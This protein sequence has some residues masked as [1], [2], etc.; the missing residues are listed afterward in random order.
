MTLLIAK[1]SY[2]HSFLKATAVRTKLLVL[3]CLGTSIFLAGLLMN[4]SYSVRREQSP[5]EAGAKIV[6]KSQG[7]FQRALNLAQPGDIIELEAGAVFTGPFT[8]PVKS[9]SEYITIQSS[10]LTE[11]PGDGK[12]VNSSH[13][14]LMP[15][16]VGV[17][18]EPAIKTA[19]KAHH[20]RFIGVEFAPANNRMVI[21]DLIKLGDG[22][23]AQNSLELVAH[24]FILDRCYIHGFPTQEVKRG[25]ALNS[26]ETWITNSYIS[27]IHGIGYD[28]QAICGWNG[29]G[30]YHIINNYLEGAGE[31]VMFG[32]AD[33]AI[34]NLVPSDIEIRRNHFFKPLSWKV[35]DP[36]YAG[37]HWTIK[38]L[39]ELKNSRRVVVDGNIFENCW[40]DAQTGFAI[41]LKSQN[42]DGNCPWCV[43]EDITFSNNIVRNA[44]NGI[45]VLAYDPYHPSAQ[46]K[47]L[48]VVN[49]LWVNISGMWFQGTDGADDVLL[50]HNTHLQRSGNVMTLYGRPTTKFVYRNN[51]TVRTGYG[52][53]GDATG[54]GI[55]ALQAFCPGYVFEK[56]VIAAMREPNYPPNNFYPSSLAD[57]GLA[58]PGTGNYRLANS[59]RY[60]H[61]GTD[62]QD[63][64]CDFAKL[65][66]A[67]SG[68]LH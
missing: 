6:V 30:P 31:N 55:P 29:P 11:L 19:P 66:A 2:V 5:T 52:V 44:E 43:S 42:Q 47:R 1:G 25:I 49:N 45:N 13:A 32:G 39:F 12:R 10:R 48:K 3:I 63:P 53:K 37:T 36:S 57:V 15:K 35:G 46:L 8:L 50:E 54:E 26:G 9:G 18:G 38:N 16:I 56:N 20:F 58:S 59:S 34:P 68:T 24:H 64:G 51:L 4:S 61:A 40:V 41:L 67:I 23:S 28:T 17:T 33:P 60:R 62:K 7:Q 14:R 65:D 21:S 27:D 22:S